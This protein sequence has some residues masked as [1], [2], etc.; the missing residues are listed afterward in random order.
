MSDSRFTN[1]PITHLGIL[2]TQKINDQDFTF[3]A[4][5]GMDGTTALDGMSPHSLLMINSKFW[6]S[7]GEVYV[8]D[9][10]SLDPV[11]RLHPEIHEINAGILISD[12]VKKLDYKVSAIHQSGTYKALPSSKEI[13]S[14]DG[15]VD[16]QVGYF[17]TPRTR[18]FL[19][20]LD[21]GTNYI[22]IAPNAYT[23][24]LFPSYLAIGNIWQ[25][26]AGLEYRLQENMH[27][28]FEHILS[29][30]HD[31]TGINSYRAANNGDA[32]FLSNE[33]DLIFKHQLNDSFYYQVGGYLIYPHALSKNTDAAFGAQALAIFSL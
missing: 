31:S 17:A 8:L 23:L 26:R 21:A 27:V 1:E 30:D 5:R 12:R 6:Q 18:I 22:S 25:E 3:F 15:F 28:S 9:V 24:G 13:T 11:A 29:F 20:Y 32:H 4:S 10:Q 16:A 2:G 7:R 19:R 14:R 33:T